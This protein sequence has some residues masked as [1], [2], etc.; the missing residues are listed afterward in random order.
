MFKQSLTRVFRAAQSTLT[1]P[2]ASQCFLYA[3]GLPKHH[4]LV[5][6]QLRNSLQS[7]IHLF[8]CVSCFLSLQLLD[9]HGLPRPRRRLRR[10]ADPSL[11]TPD[12]QNKE[13]EKLGL[14]CVFSF[15][16]QNGLLQAGATEK[17]DT[18]FASGLR[19]IV[20][21]CF[22]RRT[23]T[24]AS[25]PVPTATSEVKTK[26]TTTTV[27]KEPANSSGHLQYDD[28]YDDPENEPVLRCRSVGEVKK[29][30]LLRLVLT[31]H[32]VNVRGDGVYLELIDIILYSYMSGC[33]LHLLV[34]QD[35]AQIQ[36]IAEYLQEIMGLEAPQ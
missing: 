27:K 3:Q 5:M 34:H 10:V 4:F 22:I 26:P 12:D 21:D 31:Q 13:L 15:F 16:L 29:A 36:P 17:W 9:N 14:N 8:K 24:V 2:G 23:G 6:S 28:S 30:E 32:A 35:D 25:P 19:V 11:L 1:V 18:M 20:C 33:R 7:G